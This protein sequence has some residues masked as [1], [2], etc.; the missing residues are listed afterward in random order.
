MSILKAFIDSPYKVEQYGEW[1][2]PSDAKMEVDYG[3]GL[4]EVLNGGKF[5]FYRYF[6]ADVRGFVV[7]TC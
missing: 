3:L 1:Y 2:D 6:V 7:I 4:V 5:W